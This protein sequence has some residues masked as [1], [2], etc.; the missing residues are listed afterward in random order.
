MYYYHIL[1]YTALTLILTLF[2]VRKINQTTH[3]EKQ[4]NMILALQ[5]IV[6]VTLCG[7][8]YGTKST[9]NYMLI[10]LEKY[11]IILL[12]V[13][14][15]INIALLSMFTSKKDFDARYI[16][17]FLVVTLIFF[18]LCFFVVFLPSYLNH[19]SISEKT[20][21]EEFLEKIINPFQNVYKVKIK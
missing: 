17:P 9:I 14:S 3:S 6:L 10:P 11:F 15:V 13:F 18:C 8:I 5:S 4:F 1:W 2:F 7:Y 16:Y 12:L 19:R 21:Y 20:D